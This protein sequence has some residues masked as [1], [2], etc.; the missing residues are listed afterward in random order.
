MSEQL[1]I[2]A[3]RMTEA[4]QLL[5]RTMAV[6]GELN[7]QSIKGMTRQELADYRTSVREARDHITIAKKHLAELERARKKKLADDE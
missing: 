7:L 1:R 6:L 4:S 3:L 2:N 5:A